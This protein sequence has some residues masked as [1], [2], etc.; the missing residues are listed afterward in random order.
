[1]K[2]FIHSVSTDQAQNILFT[3]VSRLQILQRIY[4]YISDKRKIAF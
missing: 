1:M 3:T 4:K 2:H